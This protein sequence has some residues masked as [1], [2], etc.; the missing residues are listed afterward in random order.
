MIEDLIV[1]RSNYYAG[2]I[3]SQLVEFID[4]TVTFEFY[5]DELPIL[6]ENLSLKWE[7]L[8]G[9]VD[10]GVLSEDYAREAMGWPATA[11]PEEKPV[12]DTVDPELRSWKRKATKAFNRGESADVEFTTGKVSRQEQLR[13]HDRLQRVESQGDIL[14][15]F[16]DD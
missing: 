8:K 1:P 15:A 9:A 12:Q 6:Q 13:I 11:K 3:N 10:S 5:P 7:R 4:P 14:R 16:T 2:A